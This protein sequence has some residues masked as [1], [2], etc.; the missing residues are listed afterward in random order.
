LEPA[1]TKSPAAG[2]GWILAAV[3]VAADL[4]VYAVWLRDSPN[5]YAYRLL[6]GAAVAYLLV[7]LRWTT[8]ERLGLDWD[9]GRA[10]LRFALKVGVVVCVALA[11]AALVALAAVRLGGWTLPPLTPSMRSTREFFPQLLHTCVMAPIVEEFIYRGLF[12]GLIATSGSRAA[13]IAASGVLFLGLHAVYYQGAPLFNPISIAEYLISGGL[14]AWV[15]LARR[16][17]L[18]AVVLHAL[19][20]L[21]FLAANLV[22]LKFPDLPSRVLGAS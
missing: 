14:L 22:L 19:G 21:A 18:P 8:P 1:P 13:P 9:R 7:G 15:F 16:S 2:R 3:I 4:A 17:L 12:V 11:A 20:N 6:G 5:H 10:D